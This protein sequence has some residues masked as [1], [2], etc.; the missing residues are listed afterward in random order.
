MAPFN[1]Y[2]ALLSKIF[3]YYGQDVGK[4][5]IHLGALG[6]FLSA[7]AQ[8]T[9][10]IRNKDID[11]KEKQFLVPQEIADGVINVGLYY[12]ICQG[13]KSGCDKM[14]EKG[15][16]LTEKSLRTILQ[17]KPTPNSCSDYIKGMNEIFLAR[18]F[19]K[20][21]KSVGPLTNFY[22][23]SMYM[24]ELFRKKPAEVDKILDNNPM[25]KSTFG[26]IRSDELIKRTDRFLNRAAK[27]Y[28]GFKNGMGVVAAVG[29]S[30]LACNLITP[31]TRNMTASAYQKR[32]LKRQQQIKNKTQLAV[33]QTDY[34]NTGISN[35]FSHFKI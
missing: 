32:V 20:K 31:I 4:S 2:T 22:N 17:L 16:I 24:L 30:I 21:N 27:E 13:I 15:H 6:W 11:K 28:A 12:T 33:K 34:F 8:V 7:L 19:V 18:G 3:N 23:G 35:T 10:I 14:L 25:L 5:L 1:P 9:M 29:A 26:N